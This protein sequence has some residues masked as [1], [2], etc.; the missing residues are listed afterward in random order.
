M[1]S[2]TGIIETALYVDDMQRSVAFYQDVF[3]F[4]TLFES[5]RLTTLRVCPG[6]VLLIMRKGLSANA[7]VMSFGVIPPS[8]ASGDQHVAFGVL[9]ETM[10]E[11]R[12]TLEGHGIVIESA[13]D[14]PEGGQSLYFRDP[15]HHC[16]EVK[17][18][19]WNGE[20]LPGPP[21]PP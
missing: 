11:W 21:A 12:A 18:S 4:A 5:E 6:Q 17:S 14:W 2:L 13:L 9:P 20:P 19:D 15:D 10:P 16:I 7:S 8:D 1:S 3:G